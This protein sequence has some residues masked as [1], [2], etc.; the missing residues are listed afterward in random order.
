MTY[1]LD[2]YRFIQNGN[3]VIALSTYAG[4]TVRGIATCSSKD[5]FSLDKGKEL[6]AARC[7]FKIASKRLARA[8]SKVFEATIAMQKGNEYYDNMLD[9]Q[10][11]ALINYYET[12]NMLDSILA[13]L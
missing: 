6:A 13:G 8:D 3:R 10:R 9:Y 5:S 12:R 2:K 7:A 1:P 11:N 4:R